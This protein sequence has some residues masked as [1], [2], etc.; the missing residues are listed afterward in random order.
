MHA[1]VYYSPG[2][3]WRT[4]VLGSAAACISGTWVVA[5]L[6]RADP[7]AAPAPASTTTV[8]T[9]GAAAAPAPKPQ[10]DGDVTELGAWLGPRV[11]SGNSDLGSIVGAPEHLTLASSIGFGVR[12]ARPFLPWLVPEAEL[13]FVPTHTTMLSTDVYWL[14]PRVHLRFELMPHKQLMPFL[15]VGGGSTIAF[16]TGTKV[17]DTDLRADGYVGGGLRFDTGKGF[18]FRLDARLSFVPATRSGIT[19]EGDLGFGIE[20]RPGEHKEAPKPIAVIADRD[21]DKIPDDKDKCPDDPEDYDGFEDADGCPDYDND[22]DGILD[23][24]DKCP[25]VPETYNGFE[26]EDGCPDTVPPDVEEIKGTIAGLLYADGETAVRDSA[27][28][29]LKHIAEVLLKHKGVKI[30]LVGHTDDREA[31]QFAP[32]ADPKNPNAEPPDFEALAVDLSR[33]RAEAVRL[34]LIKDGVGEGKVNVDGKGTQSPVADNETPR[35]RLANRRVELQL[36][37]PSGH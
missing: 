27:Q 33:A 16:S 13:G 28:A 31:K 24:D 26:D 4:L 9:A 12:I 32:A 15:V 5:R 23:A 17:F 10:P 1:P 3:L 14:E 7:A 36:F 25:N 2:M 29:H 21:H 11:F 22:K 6:G 35:G 20:F 19:P 34:E 37:I 18:T 30:V 8:S